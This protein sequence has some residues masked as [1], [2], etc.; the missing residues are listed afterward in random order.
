MGLDIQPKYMSWKDEKKMEKEC[1]DKYKKRM[2]DEACLIK[3]LNDLCKAFND[4]LRNIERQDCFEE[5]ICEKYPFD[6]S[7]DEMVCKVNDWCDAV[8]DEL[9]GEENDSNI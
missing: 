5:I 2:L 7:F 9:K 1:A 6:L 8:V 3:S 4:V